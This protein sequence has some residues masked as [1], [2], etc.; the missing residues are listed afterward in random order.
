MKLWW[1]GLEEKTSF[2]LAARPKSGP[3]TARLI[4]CEENSLLIFA[5]LEKQGLEIR[6]INKNKRKVAFKFDATFS[7]FRSKGILLHYIP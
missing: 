3:G 5:I 4:F 6:N 7:T 1:T 2:E